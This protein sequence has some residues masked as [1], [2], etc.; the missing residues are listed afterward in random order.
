MQRVP[1]TSEVIVA[2][3]KY[4]YQANN[5]QVQTDDEVKQAGKN[6]NQDP[7]YQRDQRR[8]A[9]MDRHGAKPFMGLF[10]RTRGL[11]TAPGTLHA[12]APRASRGLRE[13]LAA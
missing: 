4:S 2:G 11:I 12:E 1:I 13:K 9:Q 7:G 6:K 10:E 8:Q 3:A 5:N